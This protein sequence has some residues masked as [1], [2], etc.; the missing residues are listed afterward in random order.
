MAR[1]RRRP[2]GACSSRRRDRCCWPGGS[3]RR[4]RSSTTGQRGSRGQS[5]SGPGG[6]CVHAHRRAAPRRARALL[7][8][9]QA[10]GESE[11]GRGR[12]GHRAGRGDDGGRARVRAGGGARGP[13]RA[14][15][16]VGD[17]RCDLGRP[18]PGSA[19]GGCLRTSRG[20]ELSRPRVGR[21]RLAP[22][23]GGRDPGGR[24]AGGPPC[25]QACAAWPQLRHDE[26]AP[27]PRR[28]DQPGLARGREVRRANLWV[29]GTWRRA[30]RAGAGGRP[31]VAFFHGARRPAPERRRARKRAPCRWRDGR[32]RCRGRRDQ[33]GQVRRRPG[34]PRPARP[35]PWPPG[36]RCRA[37]R[38]VALRSCSM[39]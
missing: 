3:C 24:A 33:R 6:G 19:R 34:R 30:A 29:T 18:R 31:D 9:S 17:D 2:P 39:S 25:G 32:G 12:P 27:S 38:S 22:G 14:G 11:A 21:R 20:R 1:V 28:R 15:A 8:R 5:H 4:G 35:R 16:P 26:G 13:G 23:E 10:R 37:A 7:D 36:A